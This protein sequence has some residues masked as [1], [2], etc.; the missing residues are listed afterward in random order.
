MAIESWNMVV[1]DT[2]VV[3]IIII[4]ETRT[5]HEDWN[6]ELDIKVSQLG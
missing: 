2:A 4:I 1:A 5:G 6:V 3:I